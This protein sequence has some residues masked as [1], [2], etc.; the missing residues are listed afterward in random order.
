M[1]FTAVG[2]NACSALGVIESVAG[3]VKAEEA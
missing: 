2:E 3:G 1:F